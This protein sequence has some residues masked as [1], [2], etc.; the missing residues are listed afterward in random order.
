MLL[1]YTNT[2]QRALEVE[3]VGRLLPSQALLVYSSDRP[4]QQK[5]SLNQP[6]RRIGVWHG[7]SIAK[8]ARRH[9]P[10]ATLVE[11]PEPSEDVQAG[12][13]DAAVMDA[14]T[15]IFMEQHPGL[16][17]LRND[18]GRLEILGQEYGHPAIRPGDPRFLNWLKNWLDYHD[19]IG[20]I[21]YWCGAWWQSWMAD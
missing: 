13:V 15:K 18:E 16:R 4:V 3:F 12:R 7:S 1:S 19:A 2:P 9:F 14:V 11:S 21:D 8:I 20:T 17:L 5:E 6:G 10:L